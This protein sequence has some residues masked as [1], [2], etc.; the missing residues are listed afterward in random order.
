MHI[1]ILLNKAKLWTYK[2]T[3]RGGIN[4]GAPKHLYEHWSHSP[5]RRILDHV[6]VEVALGSGELLR[7]P[8]RSVDNSCVDV[9]I[10]DV[11][12]LL[13]IHR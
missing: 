13:N 7:R 3:V 5:P 8:T 4:R 6:E 2:L 1:N 10:I 9:L 12:M 11:H